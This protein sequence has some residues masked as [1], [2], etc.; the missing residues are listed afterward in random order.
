[1]LRIR[2][3]AL[4]PIAWA[5]LAT[6]ALAA[7]STQ[8]RLI[9][10]VESVAPGD[11]FLA[12]LEMTIRPGWHTY[13]RNG[14]DSGAPTS[15]NWKL[16]AFLSS[17]PILWPPPAT[18]SDQGLVTFVHHKSV[19]LLVP[20]TVAPDAPHGPVTLEAAIQ[21]LECEA[22]CVPGRATVRAELVVG[23]ETR[24]SPHAALL[25][26]AVG[27]LPPPL[28]E[29]AA[30]AS[31]DGPAD[32]E[33]RTLF[34]RWRPPA[35]TGSPDFYPY[36]GDGFEVLTATEVRPGPEGVVTLRK[37][38]RLFDG[39]WPE[40]VGGLLV[41][42]HPGQVPSLA[43]DALLPISSDP[44][45]VPAGASTALTAS[46]P[47]SASI[48]LATA[49][50]FGFLGGIILNAMPCVL[51]VI[52]LKILGFVRQAGGRPAEIRRH[53]YAYSVGV[54]VSFL[55][56]AAVVIAV[57]ATAGVAGWGMQ[58]GNPVFLV[59]MT[60]L[61]LLVALSLFG[62]FEINFT[63]RALDSAGNLA[64]R[65]GYSGSFFTG[66]LAVALATPCTAPFL[67]PALGYA[68]VADA[69]TI[70]IV[71]TAVALGLAAP[72]L[73]L[74]WQPAWL[75]FVPKPGRWMERFKV[76]MGFPMLATALWLYTLTAR[77]FGE[78]GALWLG[79]FLVGLA[80]AAWVWGEFVQRGRQRQGLAIAVAL[81]VVAAFYGVALEKELQWR[82][83]RASTPVPATT[84]SN[85]E[86]IPW[87]PWSPE[88]VAAARAEGRPVFVEFTADWCLNCKLN[89][90]SS[91]EIPAVRAR[92]REINGVP[93]KGD[94]TDYP[95]AI[96]RELQRFQRAG[97]PLV[98]VYPR[99]P[100]R[101]PIVLP[102]LLTPSIVLD[103]LAEA[104]R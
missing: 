33:E 96:T 64:S 55:V 85:S 81:V 42:A 40:A 3:W 92:L 69:A 87:Q 35:G 76:A 74:S 66:V 16:P 83:P 12:G 17:E 31:W 51:P 49:I 94:H 34:I 91:I 56:L 84:Q 82:S 88:A 46:T 43:F 60:V 71:F 39:T 52:A 72:Y 79:L 80:L 50:L 68:F 18:Y 103:A 59:L 5:L 24:P 9:L 45:N 78:G 99:D 89:E 4:I 37:Q 100:A 7:Q 2:F 90:R 10:P 65:E 30:V 53:G 23:P 57:K 26:A 58:F 11:R 97:V 75:H 19:T 63:G 38:V 25:A 62:V 22:V 6:P 86:R 8:V 27:Q 1:M 13:W 44:G 41:L 21:W 93:L 29:G 102:S 67:A 28:P 15:L 98:V 48:S 70:L 104:A 101:D 14:G 32:G 20:F 54:W 36:E 77:R 95:P 61:I 47:A 73:L